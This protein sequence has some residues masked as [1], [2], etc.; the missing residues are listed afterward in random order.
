VSLF[1]VASSIG[2][3]QSEL[4]KLLAGQASLGI[5]KN[6]PT[7]VLGGEVSISYAHAHGML[8]SQAQARRDRVERDGAIGNIIGIRAKVL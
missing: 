5:A 4:E 2:V 3:V 7:K 6:W 8:Q 1:S